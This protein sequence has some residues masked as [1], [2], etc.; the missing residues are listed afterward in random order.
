LLVVSHTITPTRGIDIDPEAES[1]G[2]LGIRVVNDLI[3]RKGLVQITVFWA[4]LR[5]SPRAIVRVK[6]R[7]NR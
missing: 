7:G 1:L 3:L 6:W 5:N 4:R 2:S